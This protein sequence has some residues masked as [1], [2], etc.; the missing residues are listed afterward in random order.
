MTPSPLV[1]AADAMARACVVTRKGGRLEYRVRCNVCG[2]HSSIFSSAPPDHNEGCAVYLY[3]V[4]RDQALATR[5]QE[6]A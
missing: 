5:T 4:A 3:W 2:R 6:D 1:A